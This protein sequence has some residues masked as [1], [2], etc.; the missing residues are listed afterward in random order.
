[1]AMKGDREYKEHRKR[2]VCASLKVQLPTQFSFN[3]ASFWQ[4][5]LPDHTEIFGNVTQK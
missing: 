4:D 3:L 1:M 5:I 2:R